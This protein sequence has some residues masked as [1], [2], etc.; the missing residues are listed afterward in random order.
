MALEDR[1]RPAQRE[2]TAGHA[3]ADPLT[4]NGQPTTA[5]PGDAG[6]SRPRCCTVGDGGH[7]G[8]RHGARPGETGHL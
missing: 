4:G 5:P 2:E 3:S 7:R 1:L 8:R 6:H